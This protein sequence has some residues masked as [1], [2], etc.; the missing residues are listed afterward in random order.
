MSKGRD[1]SITIEDCDNDCIRIDNLTFS[2]TV[3]IVESTLFSN[4]H[5]IRVIDK[6]GKSYDR[7]EFLEI[8][9]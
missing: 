6:D 7:M 8:I 3:K 9:K 5:G 2:E 1:Y 4:I